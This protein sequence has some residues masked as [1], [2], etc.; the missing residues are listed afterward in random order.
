MDPG[1]VATVSEWPTLKSIREVQVFLGFAN[2]YRR[3]IEGYSRVAGP[4]TNL[5]RIKDNREGG[6]FCMTPEAQRALDILKKRLTEAPMLR[7]YNPSLPT[8]LETDASAY[9]VSGILSQRFRAVSGWITL[10]VIE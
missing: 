4:L 8:Q 1:W 3:F 9:T 6:P 2:F 10:R 7:H 5:L